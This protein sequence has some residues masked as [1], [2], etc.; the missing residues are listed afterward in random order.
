MDIK[1]LDH[2]GIVAGVIKDLGLVAE[3]DKRLQ[4]DIQNQERITAGE[5]IASMTIN[6]LGFS[7]RP[8]SLTLDGSKLRGKIPRTTHSICTRLKEVALA[9]IVTALGAGTTYA[10]GLCQAYATTV[11]TGG[12]NTWFLPANDQLN[13]LYTNRVAIGNFDLISQPYYWS[14]TE[15]SGNPTNNAWYENFFDGGQAGNAKS[16]LLGARCVQA[17]TPF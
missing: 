11:V 13:C 12:Y 16:S 2:L 9:A 7:D 6:S 14:S 1:C 5:A 8:L 10:A 15:F 3:I 17:F 4:K